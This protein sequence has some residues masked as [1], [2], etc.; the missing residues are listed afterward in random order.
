MPTFSHIVYRRGTSDIQTSAVN[1]DHIIS[2]LVDDDHF[3]VNTT[4]GQSSFDHRDIVYL[5]GKLADVLEEAKD[6][7]ES[8][9]ESA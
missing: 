7:L 8:T 2:V 6:M 5:Q 3:T 4:H 1:D 9:K